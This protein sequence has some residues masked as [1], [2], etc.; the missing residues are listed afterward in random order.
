MPLNHGDLVDVGPA[1]VRLRV[2]PRARR[3]TLR[4]SAGEVT[5][6]APSTR[7]LPE[8]VAFARKRAGWIAEQIAAQPT[9]EP[10]TPGAMIKLRGEVVP[11]V[12]VPGSGAARLKDGRIV[13]G[14]EGD[15]FAR[16]VV[17]LLKREA[18]ADF[19]AR[20][21]AHAAALGRPQPHV[22]LFDPNGRWGSCTPSRRTIRYSWR[23]ISAPPFVLDYLAAHET[24]HLVEANHSPRFWA[25]VERLHGDPER[26]RGWL[27]T[28]GPALQALGRQPTAPAAT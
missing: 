10:F 20:T 28:H 5:A 6:V 22:S 23:L 1:Q 16:R 19:R 2:N 7:R 21:E 15:A 13:S 14:G 11:L 3:L 25:L 4:V 26:A 8:V 24:A 12:A 27:K 9:P 17:N 18:L